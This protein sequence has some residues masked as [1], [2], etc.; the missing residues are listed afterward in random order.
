MTLL[1]YLYSVFVTTAVL[2]LI[3]RARLFVFVP[4]GII[5]CQQ[6]VN[7]MGGYYFDK[8]EFGDL[9]EYIQDKTFCCCLCCTTLLLLR[10]RQPHE[11]IE[12]MDSNL[13]GLETG[14]VTGGSLPP[15]V[16]QGS[17]I[18]TISQQQD[19][20]PSPAKPQEVIVRGEIV[21]SHRMNESSVSALGGI[22]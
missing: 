1:E 15:S 2:D 10:E 6:K 18:E 7:I 9:P 4:I 11:Q 17:V 21:M 19:M 12:P 22:D 3:V 8:E 16:V 20:S 5:I 13:D 14:L